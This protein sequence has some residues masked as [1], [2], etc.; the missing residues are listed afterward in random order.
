MTTIKKLQVK[1]G[2]TLS[3]VLNVPENIADGFLS[4]WTPS[5]QIRRHRNPQ[6]SGFIA[7]LGCFWVDPTKARS[8][9]VFNADTDDWPEGLADMD[10]L[11]TSADGQT[12]HS[13]TILVE[14]S[15]GVTR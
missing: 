14:I 4:S 9:G 8:V 3:L 5:A 15:Q 7:Q 13:S 6:P 10:V 1:K 11:F 12:I 2:S